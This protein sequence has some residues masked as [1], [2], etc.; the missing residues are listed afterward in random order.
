METTTMRLGSRRNGKDMET[1]ITGLGFRK[2]RQ[3]SGNYFTGLYRDYYKDP[4]PHSYLT[5]GKYCVYQVSS[6]A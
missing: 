5:K 4:F 6:K 2:N 3:E 1:A